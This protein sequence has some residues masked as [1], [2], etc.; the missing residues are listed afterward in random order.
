MKVVNERSNSDPLH[1]GDSVRHLHRDMKVPD[2]TAHIPAPSVPPLTTVAYDGLAA[3]F[4]EVM[5]RRHPSRLVLLAPDG[6][7]QVDA[8]LHSR[9]RAKAA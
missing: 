2:A 8:S 5:R 3:A 7:P 9:F 1:G 6:D 4:L